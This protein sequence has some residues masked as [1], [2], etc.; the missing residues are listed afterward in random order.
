MELQQRESILLVSLE[1][2]IERTKTHP[3]YDAVHKAAKQIKMLI[4]SGQYTATDLA[5]LNVNF[6]PLE[7]GYTTDKT[8]HK[9]I[10]DMQKSIKLKIVA[11]V[12][13]KAKC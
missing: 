12:A 6:K 10:C 3:R 1:E 8:Q 7:K 9:L 4:S 5:S 2:F 11:L 13:H